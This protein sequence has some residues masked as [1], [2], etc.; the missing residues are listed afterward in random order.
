MGFIVIW[1][2]YKIKVFRMACVV[3]YDDFGRIDSVEFFEC[4]L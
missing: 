3:V 1:Y 2:F 4:V